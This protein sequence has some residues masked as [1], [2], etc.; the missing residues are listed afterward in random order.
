MSFGQ[1]TFNTGDAGLDA[2]LNIANTEA[3]KDLSLFKNKL[4]LDFNISSPIVDKLLA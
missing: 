4:S 2:E 1:I 3:N